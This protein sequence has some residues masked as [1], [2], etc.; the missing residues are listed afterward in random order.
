MKRQLP[1]AEAEHCDRC[2][3]FVA[4]TDATVRASGFTLIPS[5]LV[6]QVTDGVWNAVV[7]TLGKGTFLIRGPQ[8]RPVHAC[9]LRAYE[10]RHVAADPLPGR[11]RPGKS[12][13]QR[14]RKGTCRDLLVWARAGRVD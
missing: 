10:I 7:A 11:K 3:A 1:A 5:R 2:P 8:D 12:A 9:P 6:A 13:D 14:D 4:D